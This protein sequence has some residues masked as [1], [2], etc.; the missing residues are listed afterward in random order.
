MRR[1]T[2][3]ATLSR[4]ALN[5]TPRLST[6]ESPLALGSNGPAPGEF[7]AEAVNTEAAVAARPDG[8]P[9]FIKTAVNVPCSPCDA[10]RA[11]GLNRAAG[12]A[13]CVRPACAPRRTCDLGAGA[14]RAPAPGRCRP[15]PRRTGG[16]RGKDQEQLVEARA[17]H[18]V[19]GEQ[20][21]PVEGE[22]FGV[23]HFV[24]Q[25][26]NPHSG[27]SRPANSSSSSG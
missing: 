24:G 7:A 3:P 12:S 14:A 9:P 19:G 16:G 21:G 20:D 18:R 4:L 11:C 5:V 8:G 13:S 27:S 23:A 25:S 10:R 2:Q 26:A 17:R 15:A 6:H 22:A 1:R